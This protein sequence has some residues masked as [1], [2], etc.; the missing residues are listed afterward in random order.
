MTTRPT[1]TP[2]RGDITEQPADVLA[3][4]RTRARFLRSAARTSR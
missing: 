1:I 3:N 2:V 4:A